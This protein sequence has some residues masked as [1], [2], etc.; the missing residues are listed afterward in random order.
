MNILDLVGKETRL[1]FGKATAQEYDT[2]CPF[3]PAQG[4]FWRRQCNQSGDAVHFVRAYKGMS[5]VAALSLLC[6]NY[7][8]VDFIDTNDTNQCLRAGAPGPI[9]IIRI[10][11]IIY[12]INIIHINKRVPISGR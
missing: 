9:R 10:I 1:T 8:Y 12:I 3:W 2:P 5:F 7:H 6:Q 4:R 11:N